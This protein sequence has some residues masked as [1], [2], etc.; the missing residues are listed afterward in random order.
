M[1][2]IGLTILTFSAMLM[3][4]KYFGIYN[5]NNLQAIVINYFTAGLL[6]IAN[7]KFNGLD[8]HFDSIIYSDYL[9][10]SLI[11]GTLFIITF[12]LV[13]FGTQKIGIAVTTVANKMSMIIPVLFG[14]ILFNEDKNILKITGIILALFAIYFSSTNKGKL[15]FDKKYLL[16]IILIFIGQGFAD[17]TLN[18]VQKY[19][20][21]SSNTQQFFAT[22]FLIA[23][24]AGLIFMLLEKI[25]KNQPFELKSIYWGIILGIPN[26][27]TLYFF[28]K[29]LQAGILE[30]SQVFPIIN[31]GIIICS[32]VGG[33]IL[34]KEQLS[35]SNWG[36][37]LLALIAIS[38][39]TF[40]S[41]FY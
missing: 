21:D 33:I 14:L 23:G 29:S 24:L 40:S 34:F 30:S 25:K 26:Y 4:F 3:I 7:A 1:I 35:K 12:N 39:I 28:I 13:A 18:W 31:M 36:G 6:A 38:M 17:G 9:I 27:L 10:P 16:I 15:S 20:I 5:V 22:T 2:E 11:I 41:I 19:R 32:A 8:Y 37:I